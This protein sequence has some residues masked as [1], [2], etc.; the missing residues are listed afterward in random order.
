[1]VFKIKINAKI[2]KAAL[3]R[4]IQEKQK[5]IKE[6]IREV[7]RHKALPHLIDLV[8]GGYDELSDR[9]EA[10]PE[11]PT[12]PANWRSEFL[13]KLREDLEDNLIL[14]GDRIVAKIGDTD[15]LG[16]DPS[17]TIDP[18]DTEPLHWLVFYIEGLAGDWGF[19][20]PEDY[21][22]ITRGKYDPQWGRFSRGFM[23]SREEYEA[24]GWSKVIPFEQIRHPFS[25]FSPLDIFSE[26]LNEFKIRP[27]VQKAIEAAVRGEKA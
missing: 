3:S 12:N 9:M 10:G 25:G 27:F 4:I 6:N 15:F 1:M 26:A 8:M 21:N 11:D 19:V 16:Y 18:A 23:I 22:T 20:T 7:M 17:G 2:D 24:Q 5:L 13:S 14:T